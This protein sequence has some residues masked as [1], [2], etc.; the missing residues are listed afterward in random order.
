MKASPFLETAVEAAR[1]GGRVLM[2][3]W[4]KLRQGQVRRK[5]PH[6]WVTDLDHASERTILALIRKAFP[7]H[8]IRA[9]ESGRSAGRAR[10]EWLV[11]P[12]DGTVNYMHSFPMFAV[13]VALARDG[14]LEAGVVYDPVREELFTA[15][16]GRGAWL[17]GKRIRVSKVEAF[18]QSLLATGFPFR[19]R[20]LIDVYLES[21]RRIFSETGSIRRAGSA[22]VDLAYTACGRMDGFWELSLSSW[23][24]AAGALLIQE[25]GGKVSDFF[26]GDSYLETGHIC[27]ANPALHAHLVALLAPIFRG[28]M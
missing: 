26:G 13:S 20:E 19:A 18:E 22:A 12:L 16:R 23:D 4:G 27:A 7:D 9:E 3:S 2:K 1:A 10:F 25:A 21:F 24:M 14:V 28:K 5:G 6:D 17:N 15:E 8:A 11:D